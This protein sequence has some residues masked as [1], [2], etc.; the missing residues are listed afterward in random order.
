MVYNFVYSD[1]LGGHAWTV[2]IKG[3][4][5][6]EL[7]LSDAFVGNVVIKLHGHQYDNMLNRTKWY[8]LAALALYTRYS[9]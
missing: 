9:T 5:E 1:S 4:N 2:P 3:P 6:N 7:P 8:N